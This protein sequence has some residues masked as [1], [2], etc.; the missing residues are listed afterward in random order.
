MTVHWWFEN[1]IL[2]IIM[3]FSERCSGNI[4]ILFYDL[5]FVNGLKQTASQTN[6][7]PRVAGTI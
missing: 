4:N 3:F 2:I 6:C 1:Y 7:L 5:T